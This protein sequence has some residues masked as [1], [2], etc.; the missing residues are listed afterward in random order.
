MNNSPLFFLLLISSFVFS[1][2]VE[3]ESLVN[4]FTKDIIPKDFEYYNLL[5]KSFKLDFDVEYLNE[6]IE[7][8]GAKISFF[9]KEDFI[10]SK[11]EINWKDYNLEKAHIFPYD[12]IPKF[13][14]A[15][16]EYILVDKK[17]S[18]KQFDGIRNDKKYNQI[19]VKINPKWSKEKKKKECQKALKKREEIIKLENRDFYSISSPFFSL[20]KK[21]AIIYYRDCC[22]TNGYLYFLSNNKWEQI[23][24]FYRSISN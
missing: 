22:S 19:V 24:K 9:R 21:F 18:Q 16:Y 11:S 13:K 4:S 12:E 5:D 10:I 20:D 14:S 2:K 23:L 15:L 6:I 17:I 7:D 8:S 3:T 1:Q